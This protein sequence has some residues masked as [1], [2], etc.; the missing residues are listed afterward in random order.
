[1]PRLKTLA[2]ERAREQQ[3]SFSESVRRAV[4]D[5]VSRPQRAGRM[6]SDPLL[7]DHAVS[8]GDVPVDLSANPDSCLYVR[9]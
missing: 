6:G 4:L 8:R 5:A 3:L 2:R 1:M 9:E 7:A